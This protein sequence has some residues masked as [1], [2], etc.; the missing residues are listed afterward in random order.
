MLI[1]IQPMPALTALRATRSS[2][3]PA[4]GSTRIATGRASSGAW[5]CL[6][7]C[8]ICTT[9]WPCAKCTSTW[10]PSARPVLARVKR[11]DLLELLVFVEQ[12]DDDLGH[13]APAVPVVGIALLPVA[14]VPRVAR[15]SL[16]PLESGPLWAESAAEARKKA[17]RASSSEPD[18]RTRTSEQQLHRELDLARRARVAGRQPR[19]V[20]TPEARAAHRGDAARL[21]E[22]R[23]VEDVERL[24]PEL[25]GRLPDACPLDDRQVGVVE[26]GPRTAL[27]ARLPKW[28]TPFT[29]S[30]KT[31]LD[32]QEPA[33][34]G[35]QTSVE[36]HRLGSPVTSGCRR[37][38]A[39]CSRCP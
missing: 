11:L 9:A 19:R 2:P 38:R 17:R 36:N 26:A 22:V 30:A 27:R 18:F 14:G 21:A 35:S 23:V 6:K 1:S 33:M 34:R 31:E 16:N 7:S 5:M 3:S 32:V 4:A 13:Q 28:L 20:M 25:D 12:R 24:G 39:G 8:W 15:E 10:M 37:G 29:G